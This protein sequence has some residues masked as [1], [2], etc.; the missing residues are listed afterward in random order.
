MFGAEQRR[1]LI[2]LVLC[3]ATGLA[4]V[5]ALFWMVVGDGSAADAAS[6]RHERTIDDEGADSDPSESAPDSSVGTK[7][8]AKPGTIVVPTLGVR[9]E[10]EEIGMSLDPDDENYRTL[11]PPDDPATVGWWR[12]GP[13]PGAQ[14]G[15]ALLLGH[16]ERVPGK[17]GV[18]DGAFGRISRLHKGDPV[19]VHTEDG[20]QR[21]EVTKIS[22][23]RDFD[24][25]ARQAGQIDDRNFPGGRLVLITCWFDGAKFTGNTFVFAEPVAS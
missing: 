7:D 8:P 15:S 23:G 21:Y 6:A 24:E 11:V 4:A 10:I 14:K 5:S 12:D 9:A 18:G 3:A 19:R 20:T 17:V 2:G 1:L 22:A 16:T 13:M 25:V